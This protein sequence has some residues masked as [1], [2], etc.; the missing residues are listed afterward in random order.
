[1]H[2]L[3]K[4]LKDIFEKYFDPFKELKEITFRDCY[5]FEIE[6]NRTVHPDY[7]ILKVWLKQG[8]DALEYKF[9]RILYISATQYQSA[10]ELAQLRKANTKLVNDL[11]EITSAS[12]RIL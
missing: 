7:D 11:L 1:M 9:A 6:D 5:G 10:E 3:E 4:D 2:Y 12:G 8:D